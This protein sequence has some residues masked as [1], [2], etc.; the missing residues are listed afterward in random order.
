MITQ[1]LPHRNKLID[2]EKK[3][4]V[5]DVS[6]I[7]LASTGSFVGNRLTLI[8]E[9]EMVGSAITYDNSQGTVFTVHEKGSY[10]IDFNYGANSFG[11]GMVIIKNPVDTSYPAIADLK[12]RS[13][14]TSAT[15]GH[16]CLSKSIDLDVGDRVAVHAA[17]TAS[18]SSNGSG[19]R[20]SILKNTTTKKFKDL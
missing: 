7:V 10:H 18:A 15:G 19:S 13:L 16:E 4:A 8:I 9:I 11:T 20:L 2:D 3:V 12:I 14:G 17:N 5:E 6:S 1:Y